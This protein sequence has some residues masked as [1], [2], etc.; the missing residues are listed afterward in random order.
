MKIGHI[1]TR[2]LKAGSEENTLASCVYQM[3]QGHDVYIIHGE[4][5]DAEY[6][7]KVPEKIKPICIKSMVHK[8]SPIQDVKA[9]QDLRNLYKELNLDVIHT[10]QSKAGILGRFA[11]VNLPNL[12]I[13]HTVHIAPFLNVSTAQKLIYTNLEKLAGVVTHKMISVSHG[14]RNAY[15]DNQIGKP[16][17][18]SVI[19]SGMN[20]FRFKNATPIE[21]WRERIGGWE[22]DKPKFVLMLASFEPR[23]RQFEFIKSIQNFI[24]SNENVVFLFVGQG[25]MLETCKEYVKNNSLDKNIR[26]L[27]FDN[28]PE[29]LISLADLCILAS[30]REGLPRVIIQYLACRK[31]TFA[32]DLPSLDE[33]ISNNENGIIAKADDFE[34]FAKNLFELLNNNEAL[35]ILSEN[36][37]NTD[38][39]EWDNEVMGRKIL[40]VYNSI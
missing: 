20:I 29:N 16:E 38:I 13:V 28:N 37:K 7:K 25:S 23:K 9:L 14:M 31:P 18:H 6:L 34:A 39:S 21:N 8:I 27:G 30:E 32:M 1:I 12:K 26:F 2:W 10:H 19:R 17:D 15:V 24:K 11:G 33:I 35:S 36:A 3:E 4:E 40:E 22:G 5:F